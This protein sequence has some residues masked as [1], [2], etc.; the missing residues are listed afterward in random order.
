MLRY[1]L[2]VK[3]IFVF[4]REF[5]ILLETIIVIVVCV[6]VVL[7]LGLAM[8]I[9]KYFG[10]VCVSVVLGLLTGLLYGF[11]KDIERYL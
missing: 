7:V 4:I 11:G 10:F 9:L 2:N 3:D 1:L 5:Y 8:G 6:A